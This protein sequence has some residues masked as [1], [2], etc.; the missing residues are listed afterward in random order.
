M[1]VCQQMRAESDTGTLRAIKRAMDELADESEAAA[2]C[3]TRF[4]FKS[5]RFFLDPLP[6]ECVLIVR[7]KHSADWR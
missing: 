4:L 2:S 7:C 5:V 6:V 3:A 1:L